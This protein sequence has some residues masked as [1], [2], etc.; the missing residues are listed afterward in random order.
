MAPAR[1]PAETCSAHHGSAVPDRLAIR[2]NLPAV[3]AT[4][5]FCKQINCFVLVVV[6]EFTYSSNIDQRNLEIHSL[7][8]LIVQYVSFTL[9]CFLF[10]SNLLPLFLC[11]ISFLLFPC[12]RTFI[13]FSI[14]PSNDLANP[15]FDGVGLAGFKS[16]ANASLLA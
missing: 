15:V 2:Y 8:F 13:P 11:F 16:R 3:K 5:M 9:L 1:L 7:Y 4:A 6:L 12:A 10:Y 14:S